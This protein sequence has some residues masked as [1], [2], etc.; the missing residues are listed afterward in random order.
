M[1][2]TARGRPSKALQSVS[3]LSVSKNSKLIH[4]IT[5]LLVYGWVADE[6]SGQQAQIGFAPARGHHPG[7]SNHVSVV[8]VLDHY[9]A[10][11]VCFDLPQDYQQVVLEQL[12]AQQV[13]FDHG[14]DYG[15]V[16]PARDVAQHP[17]QDYQQLMPE[18]V[19]A[20]QVR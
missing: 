2:R 18:L 12:I 20:Q 4:K 19:V 7:N 1:I 16:E 5:N 10:E 15:L 3:H 6:I 11:Q 9:Q 8:G 17:A 14:D 13:R